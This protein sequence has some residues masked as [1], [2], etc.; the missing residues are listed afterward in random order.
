MLSFLILIQ[1]DIYFNNRHILSDWGVST[2]T[3]KKND[4]K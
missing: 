1:L 3:R 4:E 2:K